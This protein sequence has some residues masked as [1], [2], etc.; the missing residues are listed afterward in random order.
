MFQ[1]RHGKMTVIIL[2]LSCLFLACFG[3]KPPKLD[4]TTLS[5]GPINGQTPFDRTHIEG[6]LKGYT[7]VNGVIVDGG[8][9]MTIRVLLEGEELLEIFPNPDGASIDRIV[10]RSPSIVDGNG[11]HV[12]SSYTAI[13]GEAPAPDAQ[14]GMSEYSGC[15]LCPAPGISNLTYIFDGN[16]TGPNGII[17]PQNI[18]QTWSIKTIIWRT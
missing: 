13:F 10:V 18:L 6:L 17:P 8:Q 7:I 3:G 16:W 1:P 11:F 4:L 12:G 2:A 14:P 15:V 5:I 9:L